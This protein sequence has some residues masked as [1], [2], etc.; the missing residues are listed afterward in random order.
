[1]AVPIFLRYETSIT[2]KEPSEQLDVAVP[3]TT[4]RRAEVVMQR[5]TRSIGV[6]C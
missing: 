6:V 1:M 5:S 2:V 3:D 4:S